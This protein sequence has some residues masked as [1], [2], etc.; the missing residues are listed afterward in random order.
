MPGATISTLPLSVLRPV[1]EK[2]IV[3]VGQV[4]LRAADS[5]RLGEPMASFSIEWQVA[6]SAPFDELD[7]EI[8]IEVHSR[9]GNAVATRIL[10]ALFG[11]LTPDV[12]RGGQV[13]SIGHHRA[14]AGVAALDE[15]GQADQLP[16]EL[17][18]AGSSVGGVAIPMVDG[19]GAGSQRLR[20]LSGWEG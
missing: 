17:G 8:T 6:H 20:A 4:G 16:V 2:G 12:I 10:L 9:R 11:A 15:P 19:E 5:D 13:V 14:D 1:S 3:V 7:E 18:H